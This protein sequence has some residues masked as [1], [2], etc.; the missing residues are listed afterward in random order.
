MKLP[1]EGGFGGGGEGDSTTCQSLGNPSQSREWLSE[2][3][4]H[5]QRSERCLRSKLSQVGLLACAVSYCVRCCG[6]TCAVCINL[7]GCGCGCECVCARVG[8]QKCK[9]VFDC[10]Y[11]CVVQCVILL[12]CGANVPDL[13]CNQPVHFQSFTDSA[14]ARHQ[15]TN[16]K[17][18]E[19][20]T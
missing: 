8:V 13:H 17:H 2:E 1:L 10:V 5:L 6:A 7:C 12:F 14:I 16:N 15:E 19:N 4:P 20:Q 11:A 9:C 3:A 18:R